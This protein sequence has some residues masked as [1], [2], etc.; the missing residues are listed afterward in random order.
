MRSL[1]GWWHIL[2]M[3]TAKYRL[4]R[5]PNTN[6]NT[7]T[8]TFKSV[9]C[10]PP[11]RTLLR[12]NN[13]KSQ[14]LRKHN[15]NHNNKTNHKQ[16]MLNRMKPPTKTT[17]LP[18]LMIKPARGEASEAAEEDEEVDTMVM[19]KA[20]STEKIGTIERTEKIE[21]TEKIENTETE[22]ETVTGT[23][24]VG[25]DNKDK[26]N[27]D[28]DNKDKE[29]K[30]RDKATDL[31]VKEVDK[32]PDSRNNNNNLLNQFNQPIKNSNHSLCSM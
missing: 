32:A 8:K 11:K 1:L 5:A 7:N 3:L 26:D 6:T 13:L 23:G 19:E 10:N 28:K 18:T 22:M 29:A 15:S 12:F 25:K 24:G 9:K 17:V 2:S 27:K 20:R 30:G 31:V 21:T 14:R 16:S 4:S